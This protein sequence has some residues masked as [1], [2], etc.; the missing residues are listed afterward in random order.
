MIRKLKF[1]DLFAGLGGFHFALKEFGHECV[2]ASEIQD[3]ALYKKKS[4]RS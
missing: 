2:L 1:I 4:S 3:L